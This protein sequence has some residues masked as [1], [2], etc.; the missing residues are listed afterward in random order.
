MNDDKITVRIDSEVKKQLQQILRELGLDMSSFFKVVAMQT[1]HDRALPFQPKLNTNS[2]SVCCADKIENNPMNTNA[3]GNADISNM[4]IIDSLSKKVKPDVDIGNIGDNGGVE[5]KDDLDA[6]INN[7]TSCVPSNE[8]V[9]DVLEL[10]DL[11]LDLELDNLE[12][13]I[14]DD[15]NSGN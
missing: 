13:I 2:T 11:E 14:S 8:S 3:E 12:N 15:K 4:H 7:K 9:I 5:F 10:D 1:I 6:D